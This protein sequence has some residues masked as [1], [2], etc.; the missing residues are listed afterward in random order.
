[1]MTNLIDK[2]TQEEIQHFLHGNDPEKYIVAL[3]YSWRNGQIYKI[4]EYP[5][6][7]KVI[8]TDRFI[9]FCWVGDLS[10]KNFYNGDKQKQKKAISKH[11]I[12]IEK[13][14]TSNDERLINGLT[15]LIKTTKT[16]R[17]LVSFFKQG[18]LN[19]WEADNRDAIMI[20]SP[21]EQYLVQKKK[22]LF[23]GFEEYDDIHRFVFDLET[24]ALN[25]EDGRI[26]M[27][28]MKDN[29]GFEKVIEIGDSE[30]EESEAIYEFFET[31]EKLKPTIIGGYNSSNFD[32]NWLFK[33]AEVL[34]MDTTRFKTL[35]PNEGY[36]INDGILKLGA[37][38]EDYKQIKI[39]G[40]NSLDIAHAVRRAQT[41]NSEIKSWGLK[42]ITQ[43][44]NSQKPNRIYVKGDKIAST[45]R[46]NK[47]FYLNIE[48]GKYKPVG[49]EGLYDIDKKFP[50]TYTKVGGAEIVERYLMDD[51]WE[52]MEVDGQFNQASF[53]LASMVP[54]SYERISTMGTATLWKMLMLAWSYHKGLAVPAKDTKRPFVGGLSRLVK[55]GYSTDVLKLDFSSLYPSIQLVHNVFPEC[56]ITDAMK[57]MLKYFRDT[58]IK[59]KN[60]ASEYYSKDK[61]KSESFGRKQL[62]IKIFINSMFG[63]LS[64]PQV[65]PWGDM[66]MGEKVTCTARQYLRHMVRFFIDKGYDPLV[67]DT[68]GVNFSCPERVEEREYIGI[69][70]N[71]LVEKYK[72][73]LGSEADVAEYNDLFM[74]GE[75][76]LDTDGQWP[77]CINIARK[78]YALLTPEK[79]VKLTGNSIKSKKIQGYLE[80]FIDKGLTLLLEGN[81]EDFVEYYYEYLQKIYNKDIV[82]ANIANKSRVKQKI[83]S[84]K[85]RCKQRTKAGHL[86]SRQAHMELII[87][88]NIPVS[89][90]DTIYYVN[91]GTAMSHGD[92]QR[93]K[94][95]DGTEEIVLNSYLI[96]EN[97]LESGLKGEYNVPRYIST[98]N[99]RVEPLLVCF[100]PEVR[101]S[102]LKKNP[103]NREYYTKTQC[104][105]I[106]GVPRKESD[107]DSLDEILTLSPEEKEY[108]AKMKLSE[109]YF[110]EELNI[111]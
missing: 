7:G 70:N 69:G 58:R 24:T 73:Y 30:V 102:I 67:M 84:Y 34:Q 21:I 15:Y 89:L 72:A 92:V 47:E 98:F 1:M 57:G 38:I 41:I 27:V 78:N 16:Y 110:M 43:F 17:D 109:N 68:D 2:A 91:N 18:G 37:E 50:N 54:T 33:R 108:W 52:T 62:P 19:P 3:E 104:Q 97:D 42:Y 86:M 64:A 29:R 75:M 55:T 14:E 9:P 85:K 13:L 51:L 66:N 90:G 105:L 48:N 80:E 82:L 96:S 106:N 23:K 94:K 88:N 99:K 63:S 40:C 8:E 6:K 32:W 10:K 81:G 35:N 46:E 95:K 44:S 65:F 56:D 28:G 71:A 101:E 5:D 59:Y 93:K 103:E 76:G 25:P 83:D 22:R 11:G 31:I 49:A 107:Q 39:W 12:L 87:K 20:L 77:A 100:K 79:T 4:K 61:K 60:L 111:L 74:R 45:Y 36:K 26:F 53:L